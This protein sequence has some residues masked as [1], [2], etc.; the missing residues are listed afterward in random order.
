M[1]TE[2][3]TLLPQVAIPDAQNFYWKE[4]A[5]AITKLQYLHTKRKLL[6]SSIQW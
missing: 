6:V 5:L 4:L 3:T 2:F 1:H